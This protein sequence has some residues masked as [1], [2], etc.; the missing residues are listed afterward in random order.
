MRTKS[1]P[2]CVGGP[3][4]H[5]NLDDK[6]YAR[7]RD[8]IVSGRYEPGSRIVQE[9]LAGELGVSRTPLV[10]ALKRLAQDGLLE[11]IP[12]R[13]IHVRALEPG[14]L[15]H[16][17]VLR[18]RLEPLAAELAARNITRAEALEM[19]AEWSSMENLADTPESHRLFV[20]RDRRF[21]WRLAQLSG[22]P[23]L[24]AAMTPVNMLASAYLHGTPRPWSDTIPDHLSI[25][26]GLKRQ[27]P[28]A[29][30][31]AMRGHVAKS[32]EALRKEAEDLSNT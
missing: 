3:I 20:D 8:M 28:A 4:E 14:E 19:E 15:V 30:G 5:E 7:V 27:D 32:L 13:G 1:A 22:N 25:I 11:W 17:F 21:H 23:Y 2:E 24:M 31:E 18:E 10:N 29:S 12:R 26:E 16:L 9:D 6:V